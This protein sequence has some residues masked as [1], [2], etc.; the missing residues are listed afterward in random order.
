MTFTSRT[1]GRTGL[2]VG[3][4]GISASYGVPASAIEGAFDAGMNYLYWGSRR[5]GAFAQ[6]LRSLAPRRDGIVFVLQSYS[7]I[8]SLMT[9]SVERALRMIGYDRVDVLLLGWWNRPLSPRILDTA[10][11]LQLRGLVR[12]LGISS[13][14]RNLAAGFASSGDFDVVHLRYNAAHPGAETDCFPHL[15]AANR[16]AIVAFTATSWGQLMNPRYT[17]A[18]ERTP[19]AGDCYRFALSHAAV[20]LCATGPGSAAHVEHALE[21]VARGPMSADELAWMKRVGQV[22]RQRAWLGR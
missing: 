8:P 15:P 17:P 18:G 7:R 14:N 10:R 9:W 19:S 21:A 4:L 3:P 12:F 22:V 5:S 16:P 20:D 11:A 1:L 2:N 6:A 13:H